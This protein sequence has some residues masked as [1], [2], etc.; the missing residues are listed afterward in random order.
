MYLRASCKYVFAATTAAGLVFW[1]TPL[2]QKL[3]DCIFQPHGSQCHMGKSKQGVIWS[4]L[5]V[6]RRSP[7]NVCFVVYHFPINLQTYLFRP[8]CLR[9]RQSLGNRRI[10]LLRSLTDRRLRLAALRRPSPYL[11]TP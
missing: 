5:W 8:S 7:G 11:I 2:L 9:P 6:L 10:L 4:N 1:R 3:A